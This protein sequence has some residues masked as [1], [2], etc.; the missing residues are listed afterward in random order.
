MFRILRRALRVL[1]WVKGG[2][3]GRT[4]ISQRAGY[5]WLMLDSATGGV[6]TELRSGG[7]LSTALYSE[8][9]I[10]DGSWHRIGFTWDGSNRRL[11]VDDILVAE[12]TD[13]ALAACDGGLNIGCGKVMV[14]GSLFSGMIDDVRI[15]SRAVKP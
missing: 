7:R 13:V 4:I 9:V 12:D 8:A 5:D 15:Y 10:A 11:Y 1:A 14:P 6:M 2:E 3:H